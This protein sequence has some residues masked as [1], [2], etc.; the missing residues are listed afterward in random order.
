VREE[1]L[2]IDWV[3]ELTHNMLASW[4]IIATMLN[5]HRIRLKSKPILRQHRT[6]AE[7]SRRASALSREE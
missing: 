7:K 1:T 6:K 5:A 2:S 4:L 3:A